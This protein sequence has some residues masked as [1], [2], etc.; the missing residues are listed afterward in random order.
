MP[1]IPIAAGNLIPLTMAMGKFG[2][3]EDFSPDVAEKRLMMT[4]SSLRLILSD[5]K[6]KALV[7]SPSYNWNFFWSLPSYRVLSKAAQDEI[8]ATI[9][10]NYRLEFMN[11]E[12]VI[13]LRISDAETEAL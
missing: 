11:E 7:G 9:R 10:A 3:T 8:S 2:I 13:F 1:E 6:T 4:P 5:P 12:Y